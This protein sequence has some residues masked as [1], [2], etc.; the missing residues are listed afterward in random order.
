MRVGYGR[1]STRDQNR[2]APGPR[3]PAGYV[4]TQLQ[5]PEYA[6]SAEM[7]WSSTDS[8]VKV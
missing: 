5:M 3:L 7:I 2:L 4:T 6:S 1:V 8:R